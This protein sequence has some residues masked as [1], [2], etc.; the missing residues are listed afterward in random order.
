VNAVLNVYISRLRRLL[1]NG[2]G[3]QPLVTQAAGYVLRVVPERLDAHRFETLLEQGRRQLAKGDAKPAVTTLR[4]ALALWRGPALADL[5]YQPFAQSEISRLEELRLT[6][7]EERIEAELLLGRNDALVPELEALVARHPYRERLRAQ[8]MLAL[9]RCG[10][11]A[12]ALDTYRRTRRVLVDELGIE[13]GPQLQ[14]L[15]RAVLRHDTS[16]QLPAPKPRR[17]PPEDQPRAALPKKQ[18]R[19]RWALAVAAALGLVIAAAVVAASRSPSS[20]SAMPVKLTGNSVA[21]I[22]PATNA[23][24]DEIPIGGRPGGIAAGEESIWV[25]NRDDKTLLRIDPSSREVVR[26]IGLGLVPADVG[27]GAGGVWVLSDSLEAVLRIDPDI[28][29][30]VG[31]FRQRRESVLDPPWSQMAVGADAVWVCACWFTAGAL[32]R[33]DPNTKNSVALV[34]KGPVTQISYGEGA[35]WALTGFEGNAIE[36]IDARTNAVVERIPRGRFGETAG[37]YGARITAG[38]GAVWIAAYSG[39]T[40][41]KIDAASGRFTGSVAL[42][43]T[44]Q[45]VTTENGAV[46]VV[47]SDGTL[48][49]IDA[50]SDKVLRTIPL[51]A[52]PAPGGDAIAAGEGAVW[53]AVTP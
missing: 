18:L 43:H 30:V 26:R 32:S 45:S 21:V 53:V 14:E 3:D 50:K 22:D 19:M 42:G 31:T 25:G 1:A 49:R 12:E 11:Q 41:W 13:P 33:I 2:D 52:H 4:S 27:V 23:I 8:L 15:E 47:A 40:L 9:Y 39:K 44:P 20:H 16:L 24:V 29:D 36:R 17:S 51:G 38:A 46:W 6:A 34:R 48:L 28:N 37:G 7:L 35:L 5:A 10:R